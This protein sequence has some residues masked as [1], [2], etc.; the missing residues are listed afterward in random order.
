MRDGSSFKDRC[1]G[2][3][4]GHWSAVSLDSRGQWREYVHT[5]EYIYLEYVCVYKI[6]RE[7]LLL[8]RYRGYLLIS[9]LKTLLR[10]LDRH[11][12]THIYIYMWIKAEVANFRI[13]TKI[14]SRTMIAL[15]Y[16]CTIPDYG[17]TNS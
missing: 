6:C 16:Y 17:Y 1:G 15:L 3:S 10:T 8:Y 12:T 9:S 2:F 14:Q 7:Q 4:C 13:R 11:V 5:V